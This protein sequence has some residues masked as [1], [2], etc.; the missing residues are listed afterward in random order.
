MKKT[1]FFWVLF[2]VF[3]GGFLV[4]YVSNWL[5]VGELVSVLLIVFAHVLELHSID[6]IGSRQKYLLLSL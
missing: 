2:L 4:I 1:S 6:R 3:F 5:V